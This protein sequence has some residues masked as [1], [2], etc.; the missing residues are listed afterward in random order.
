[1]KTSALLIINA[2]SSSIKFAIYSNTAKLDLLHHG[3]ITDITPG[4]G[5]ILHTFFDWLD[6]NL[7]DL[8]LQAVGHRIVHGGN[9]FLEPTRVTDAFMEKMNTLIPLAPQHLPDNLEAIKLITEHF[10]NIQQVACFDTAFHQTQ[11]YLAKLFALPLS[12]AKKGIIRYGFHGLS[13]EYIASILPEHLGEKANGKVITAHL[14]SGAS[15]C[16]MRDRKSVCTTMGFSPL[17]GLMMA[18]RCGQIDP[19]VL[20]Y[21]LQEKHFTPEKLSKLLYEESGMLGISGIT[22]DV[23]E[24][25]TSD[26][27]KAIEAI[28][29]F[30]YRAACELSSLCAT[31]EGC[32]AIVFTAGIGEKSPVIRKKICQRL[33]WL[34]VALDNE[35]NLNNSTLISSEKSKIKIYV[36]PTNEAY[37]IAKHTYK[38]CH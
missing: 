34:G 6:K 38:L 7:N 12:Y 25:S 35:E 15:M 23:Q 37:I 1:M 31:I 29:L 32:D 11:Y 19:G 16:A 33:A 24:L 36:L 20:L 3:E 13:Y 10:P 4:F 5:S 27:P 21:L 30:C 28:D 2:G 8:S 14:G 18:K 22:D 26:D 17:D 9:I